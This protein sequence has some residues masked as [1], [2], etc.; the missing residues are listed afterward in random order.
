MKSI[1]TILLIMAF[2]KLFAQEDT[3]GPH[4][5]SSTEPLVVDSA[6]YYNTDI[7][8]GFPGGYQA[9]KRYLAANIR[10]SSNEI[11]NEVVVQFL[12]SQE[13][14]VDS[15]K[16]LS[17]PTKLHEKAIR[18]VRE[19]IW[20]PGILNGRRVNSWTRITIPF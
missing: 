10:Y 2:G 12:V 17:G 7:Q 3:P 16:V 15:A 4:P 11:Q 20:T 18:L 5:L 1:L 19:P 14:K 6:F 13:G 9:W 8:P